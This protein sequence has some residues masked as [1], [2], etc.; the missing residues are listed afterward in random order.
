MGDVIGHGHAPNKKL[1]EKLAALDACTK[2]AQFG[3]LLWTNNGKHKR[4]GNVNGKSNGGSS[5]NH[6]SNSSSSKVHTPGDVGHVALCPS[7]MHRDALLHIGR[8]LDNVPN[9]ETKPV[10]KLMGVNSIEDSGQGQ[11]QGQGHSRHSYNS[12]DF[13]DVSRQRD[14]SEIDSWNVRHQDLLRQREAAPEYLRILE[15]TRELPAYKMKDV[16]I[17]TIIANRVTIVSGD[18]GCGKTTQVTP[19]V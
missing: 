9:I 4:N 2:L 7:D 15:K 8:T 14:T 5:N 6:G 16:T 3:R 17:S 1:A 13:F 11:G 10:Q 19:H 12:D 18:T